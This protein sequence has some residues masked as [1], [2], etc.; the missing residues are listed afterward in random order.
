MVNWVRLGHLNN[1]KNGI[2][3]LQK[4]LCET[5]GLRELRVKFPEVNVLLVLLALSLK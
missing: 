4:E 1:D 3:L 2:D 5:F